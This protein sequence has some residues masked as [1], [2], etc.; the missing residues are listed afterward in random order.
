MSKLCLVVRGGWDGHDPVRA[1]EV[2]IPALKDVGFFVDVED[3]P[4]VYSDEATLARYDLI[5]QCLTM[6]SATVDEISGLR[7]AVAN[8]A[9]FAG[10][11]GGIIDSFRASTDYL[12][13]VGA[14]F[15]AHPHAPADRGRIDVEAYREYTV[16]ITP[17]GTDHPITKGMSDFDVVTEQY[18]VLTDPLLEVLADCVL[19]PGNGDEWAEPVTMPVAWTRTWGRGRIF[20]TSIGHT[21]DSLEDPPVRALIEKGLAWAAR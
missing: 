17:A 10:W 11:H 2:F 4:E 5:V 14:Q 7:K 18:W 3:S 6:G 1:T 16:R 12:Q 19:V 13:L 21:V 20:A 15:A 9:G 8:G